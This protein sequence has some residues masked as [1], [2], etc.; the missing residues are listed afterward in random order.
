MRTRVLA[1]LSLTLSLVS[2][3]AC[4][5]A[6]DAAAEAAIEAASG[7][8]VQ[9]EGNKIKIKGEDGEAVV[10]I[11]GDP[12]NARIQITGDNGAATLTTG[13]DIPK[14]F[15]LGIVAGGK[16]VSALS[17]TQAGKTA[18]QVSLTA[19]GDVTAAAAF[20]EKELKGKGLT[21]ER[22]EITAD[23]TRLIALTGRSAT[24]E[25]VV[26]AQSNGEDD[27]VVTLSWSAQ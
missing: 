27:A 6:A 2:S 13:G 17:S 21:V 9:L 16:V 22:S 14:G 20:Y 18:Y 12:N 8:E 7:G 5:K 15:P 19:P 4:Q 1:S 25:A 10:D 11:G 3:T 24:V 23:G 26:S